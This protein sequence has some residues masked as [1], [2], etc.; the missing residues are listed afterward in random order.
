MKYVFYTLLVG[1]LVYFAY[2]QLWD[3]FSE[4]FD[5]V[6]F[7]SLSSQDTVPK[8]AKTKGERL[9]LL[10][11]TDRAKELERVVKNPV[12]EPVAVVEDVSAP[13]C[14]AIG[15]FLDMNL[16]QDLVAQLNALELPVSMQAID[17]ATGEKDYRLMISAA[18]SLS[19]AY[20][21]HKELK[22]NKIESFV[23]TKGPLKSGISLGIF[24]TKQA[25]EKAQSALPGLGYSTEL[26]ETPRMGREYWVIPSKGPEIK[27]SKRLWDSL[28]D[29]RP[30]LR[31]QLMTC[32]D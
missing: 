30:N 2:S 29:E 14:K 5:G 4:G 8:A 11:E 7:P 27:I 22:S 10:Q 13:N 18:D 32:I 9:T 25:A 15:P 20:R 23:I 17:K 12:V 28:A 19:E 31:R 21:R 6:I 3:Q 24:S 26:I 16:G 1:N